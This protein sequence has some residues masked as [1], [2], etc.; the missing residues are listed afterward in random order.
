MEEPVKIK[1]KLE[2]V[3]ITSLSAVNDGIPFHLSIPPIY[4][5]KTISKILDL[6][7]LSKN[8]KYVSLVIEWN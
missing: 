6:C 5:R 1:I 3:S 4:D 8:G 7:E 2:K